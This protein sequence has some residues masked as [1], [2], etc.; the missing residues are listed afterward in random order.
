MHKSENKMKL[1]YRLSGAV[2]FS[3][4]GRP[5]LNALFQS[6]GKRLPVIWIHMFTTSV[7]EPKIFLSAPAP[8]MRKSESRLR[9][10]IV[11]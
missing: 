2:D 5:F 3:L 8:R 10:R 9:L 1:C 11:L 6:L 4:E 7:V